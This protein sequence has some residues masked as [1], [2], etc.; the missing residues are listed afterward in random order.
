M[1]ISFLGVFLI[2]ALV[3]L[4]YITIQGLRGNIALAKA[5]G[6]RYVIVPFYITSLPWLLLQPVC[7]PILDRLPERWTRN[8]LPYA[9][10][11]PF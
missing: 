9:P 6:L 8:W 10:Q 3:L 2:S 11:F 4:S 1:I 5:T 7:L